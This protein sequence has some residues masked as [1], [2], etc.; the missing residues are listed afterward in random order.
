[1]MTYLIWEKVPPRTVILDFDLLCLTNFKLHLT[2]GHYVSFE[3]VDHVSKLGLPNCYTHIELCR[4]QQT[5]RDGQI[6]TEVPQYSFH[7]SEIKISDCF[8]LCWD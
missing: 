1:M 6:D 8:G 7:L 5:L 4:K 2:F 3:P